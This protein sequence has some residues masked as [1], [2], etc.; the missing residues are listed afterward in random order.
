MS[1][2]QMNKA[3]FM[4]DLSQKLDKLTDADR[5]EYMSFFS[6]LIDDKIEEGLA[7]ASVVESLGDTEQ[8]AEKI[9]TSVP[10]ELSPETEYVEDHSVIDC[11]NRYLDGEK[12]F[13]FTIKVPRGTNLRDVIIEI[14]RDYSGTTLFYTNLK[15]LGESEPQ[16]TSV[17]LERTDSMSDYYEC[18]T[19]TFDE[20]GTGIRLYLT[21]EH[22]NY[23][24]TDISNRSTAKGNGYW[25]S[26]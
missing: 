25:L 2:I 17:A 3:E 10:V 26:A 12:V 9:L 8:L 21:T 5:E 16:Q 14:T 13:H 20:A 22:G 4:N 11:T 7:E 1:T 15:Y 19:K 24:A 6:E 18:I 23:M